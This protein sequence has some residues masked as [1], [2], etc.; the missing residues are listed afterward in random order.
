[1]TSAAYAARRNADVQNDTGGRG[2][3]SDGDFGRGVV[4]GV[5][6]PA[7]VSVAKTWLHATQ[8]QWRD[9]TST[10]ASPHLSWQ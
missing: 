7:S 4:T 3:L 1:M 10:S 2:L 6:C 8:S 5:V 9:P